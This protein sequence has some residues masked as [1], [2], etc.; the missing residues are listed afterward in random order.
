MGITRST[1]MT[2]AKTYWST[3]ERG[4]KAED[5]LIESP[6]DIES[7]GTLVREAQGHPINSA[8]IMYEKIVKQFPMA[9]RY[10]KLYIEQEMQERNF[11][12]VEKLFQ[13]CLMKV[14]HIDLWK[15]YLSYVKETKQNMPNFREK[16]IQAYEFAV[17]KVGIDYHSYQIWHEYIAF[18]KAGEAVGAYAENQKI[19]AIRKVYTRAVVTP[20][21]SMEAL[22]RD[23]NSFEQGVNKLLAEKLI[24]DKT[25]DHMIA[26]KVAKAYEEVTRG[27]VR[28]NPSVPPQ[29]TSIE[30]KQKELWRRYISWEKT[31]P[32]KTE[33][34]N[35]FVK[36]VTF[37][38]EQ[39]LLSMG[40]HPD[41]WYE[42]ALFLESH[43]KQMMERGDITTG[44]KLADDAASFY[45]RATTT[46]LKSNLMLHFAHAEFEESRKRIQKVHE[47]YSRLLE[48]ADIDPTLIFIQYMK[49]ARRAEGIK[50]S[51][52]IF[53]KAREDSRCRY[54]IFVVAALMEHFCNKDAKV[55]H[56]IFELG[57]KKYGD[58][59]DY[60]LQYLEY[61]IHLNDDNNTR[62]LF[63]RI[64]NS[65]SKENC[66]VIM[67]RYLQ[68]ESQ[69]GDLASI[70]KIDRRVS[71]ICSET[72]D[73]NETLSL[74]DRYRYL[75]LVPCTP[76]ELGCMGYKANQ[77]AETIA[78]LSTVS[79]ERNK[80]KMPVINDEPPE[81]P[82]PDISQ[83][84]P[85][86]PIPS[87]A[88]AVGPKVAPGGIFPPPDAA[89][90][91]LT[92]LPPPQSFQGPFVKVDDLISL[93]ASVN[94]DEAMAAKVK[95]SEPNEKLDSVER[96]GIKRPIN[97]VGI[98]N[99]EDSDDDTLVAPPVND[100]YRQRQ[101][102]R[103]HAV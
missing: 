5:K 47:I 50:E 76:N 6:Y 36:R 89:L 52:A 73:D 81:Y 11:E 67:S 53:R 54:H 78:N 37:A 96:R 51:R 77:V 45:E 74:L 27:L 12:H 82:K 23:Y 72:L 103:V 79:S 25:R 99:G 70:I 60:V 61:K 68:F 7:W 90:E 35:L 39:A 9:G 64:L 8:S 19:M 102:K 46:L 62:V 66:R 58:N 94:I 98:A 3:T 26:R 91:L 42:A 38:Y 40:F 20:L 85:F 55:A 16:M 21:S 101:Q 95:S 84:R 22:W 80:L 65:L 56:N 15:C 69:Y 87:G 41:I 100:I 34:M 49:F 4:R 48:Q 71:T 86:K 33:D 44:N 28:G 97:N 43:S 92:R 93:I 2:E 14:L 13:R 83:M 17:D 24:H 88:I 30:V 10:W 75:D 18:L 59:T 29:L 57:M 31:N 32:T 63:E 1:K